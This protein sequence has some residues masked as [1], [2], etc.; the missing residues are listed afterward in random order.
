MADRFSMNIYP[1][2]G[3][4]GIRWEI[5]GGEKVYR[6]NHL[7]N[8]LTHD[9][10]AFKSPEKLRR[11]IT[12]VKYG[13]GLQE[14]PFDEERSPIV[15]TGDGIS[16][17]ASKAFKKIKK[18]LKKGFD[19][20]KS[21]VGSI[22]NKDD[23]VKLLASHKDQLIDLSLTFGVPVLSTALMTLVGNP[24]LAPFVT[25]A[26]KQAISMGMATK[27]GKYDDLLDDAR[28]VISKSVPKGKG[29]P[30]STEA[31]ETRNRKARERR[32]KAK[33]SGEVIK[34][35]V[36]QSKSGGVVEKKI[37]SKAEKLESDREKSL[38]G[39]ER[40]L[41]AKPDSIDI[42]DL[43]PKKKAAPKKKAPPKEVLDVDLKLNC[44]GELSKR[45]PKKK[46][47][48]SDKMKRRNVV[49]K[50]IMKEQNLKMTDASAYVK[51]HK[52]DY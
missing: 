22:K 31:R 13:H 46:R 27:E 5:H 23:I 25:I 3:R 24:E 11:E 42:G 44:H 52:I 2:E 29:I 47:V 38:A 35:A 14:K 34:K 41:D 18:P 51:E 45:E 21:K 8:Y 32:A 16:L 26:L 7:D 15:L 9:Y 6:S 10:R 43:K 36:A 50:R 1:A 33:A 4:N 28:D 39:I 20:I 37:L 30:L 48:Q 40:R 19:D 12:N 17:Y 49:V